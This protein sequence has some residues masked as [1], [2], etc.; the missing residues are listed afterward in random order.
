MGYLFS[1]PSFDPARDIPNLTGKVA[2]V[3]GANTGVGLHTAEHLALHGAKVYLACRTESKARAAIVKLESKN[4]ALKG[5]GRLVWL[6]LDLSSVR[7]AKKAAES[8]LEKESRLDIIV[9]NAAR[10]A[11]E[12][13]ITDEGLEMSVSVNHAGH[14]VFI[15][16]LLPVLKKTAELPDAD[17][18]VVA[19][20]SDAH[21]LAGSHTVFASLDDLNHPQSKPSRKNGWCAR[22]ARYA[23]TKLMSILFVRELQRQLDEENV[24]ITVIAV[25]PG[26]PIASEN[27]LER[28]PFGVSRIYAAIS[29][30][31]DQGSYTSL[32]AATSAR[33]AAERPQFKGA[34]LEPYGQI[35]S[36][37][38]M[39][40]EAGDV[41]LGKTL[42]ATTE[43]VVGG[44]LARDS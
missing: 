39:R 36:V 17:V 1:K 14:F 11:E 23:I 22:F 37:K 13:Q 4:P 2:I 5:D 15:T 26:G 38:K 20:S 30:T 6:P 28:L 24:P 8:F 41:E 44:I 40:K 3:T 31:P 18:R 9:S 43:R 16:T 27:I 12:Y 25:H 34:Y 33:V 19:V 21:R 32:F 29:M 35:V 42:W 7:N 10:L